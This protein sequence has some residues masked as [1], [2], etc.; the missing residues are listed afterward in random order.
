MPERPTP[1]PCADCLHGH[2]DWDDRCDVGQWLQADATDC[3][4]REAVAEEAPC[5]IC[6]G[7]GRC[8]FTR[9][10]LAEVR[11]LTVDDWREVHDFTVRVFMPFVHGVVAKA[12]ARVQEQTHA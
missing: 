10:R 2:A 3:Y 6:G 4:W 11:E 12:K 8:T 9:G 7:R 5:P 1:V